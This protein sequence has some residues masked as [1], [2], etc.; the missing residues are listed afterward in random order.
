MAAWGSTTTPVLVEG[1]PT[2]G[3]PQE[4]PGQKTPGPLTTLGVRDT[5]SQVEN[6]QFEKLFLITN[7]SVFLR[8]IRNYFV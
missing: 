5:H 4:T 7:V 6:H 3:G 1:D 8:D 2:T